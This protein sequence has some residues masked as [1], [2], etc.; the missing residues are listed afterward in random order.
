MLVF[1]ARVSRSVG[2][3]VGVIRRAAGRRDCTTAEQRG[4]VEAF[5]RKC[6]RYRQFVER[7][8]EEGEGRKRPTVLSIDDDKEER[9]EEENG[10]SV[11]GKECAKPAGL[12]WSSSIR[13]TSCTA[14]APLHFSLTPVVQ[15]LAGISRR[16]SRFWRCASIRLGLG[17]AQLLFAIH[18]GCWHLH[19]LL[20]GV[21]V[22]HGLRGDE[23]LA[24]D[25]GVTEQAG[26]RRYGTDKQDKDQRGPCSRHTSQLSDERERT[27]S[28]SEPRLSG[29][30]P[31][32]SP[33]LNR[34]ICLDGSS[35]NATRAHQTG[36]EPSRRRSRRLCFSPPRLLP[37]E[38]I[39]SSSVCTQRDT[40]SR[41]DNATLT[42]WRAPN[43]PSVASSPSFCIFSDRILP[44][45]DSSARSAL[46]S[47]CE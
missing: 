46:D 43:S 39:A 21:V 36:C 13:R 14:F 15:P 35:Q 25:E 6:E 26:K 5:G 12:L 34:L 29:P 33:R 8:K 22:L 9:S 44:V 45:D 16:R 11:T 31:R 47:Q 37:T 4:H 28:T 30:R 27:K 40:T 23:D 32:R 1:C 17:A 24:E 2:L 38:S 3:I 42:P 19:T 18:S 20:A 41:P 7:A 10:G